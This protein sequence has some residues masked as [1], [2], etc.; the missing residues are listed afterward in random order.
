MPVQFAR[1]SPY[2]G[3]VTE[4]FARRKGARS[5]LGAA[6][7]YADQHGVAIVMLA[8]DGAC[9]F[10]RNQEGKLKKREYAPDKVVWT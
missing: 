6:R 2:T 5:G 9:M 10:Y 4:W 3:T 1:Q 7:A 8:D